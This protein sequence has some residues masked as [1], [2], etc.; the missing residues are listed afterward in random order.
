MNDTFKTK[1]EGS[2]KDKPWLASYPEGVPAEIPPSAYNSLRDLMEKN[3]AAYAGRKVFTSMGKSITYAELEQETRKVAAWLQAHGFRKGDR[4]AV[5]MPNILQNPIAVYGILRAGMIVVNINPLYTAR[6]L[7]YQLKDSGAKV[8]FVLE[9]FAHTAQQAIIGTDIQNV[10]VASIGDVFGAKGILINFVLRRVKK[11][12]PK[13][14]ISCAIRYTD[15]MKEANRLK[16][17]H[18]DIAPED[19]AFLQYTG[20]TTG[21]SKGAVLTHNNLL[22]NKAQ[23]SLWLDSALAGKQRPES[24]TFLCALPLCHIF[25]LTVNSLMGVALGANNVLIA[26][27]R[28]IPALIKEMRHH[29][30][31]VFPG[32]NTL[33]NALLNNDDFKTLDFSELLLVLG[34]GMAVQRPVAERW[35]SVTG[36]PISE[37]YGLSET[38]PVATVNRLD[39]NDFTGTIGLPIPSTE[40]DIR[41]ENDNSLPF[42]EV[43]EICIRGP[44][45][46][47]G[48]WQRPDETAKVMA[49]DGYFRSGDMG[50]MDERGYTKIVDRKK[51]M[52][53]VSGFNV[54]PNEIE[55]VVAS[56]PGVLECAVVGIPDERSGE[57]VKLFVVKKD[58]NLTAEE[59]KAFCAENMTNY[60]RPRQIEFRTELPKTN[61]GKILRREL[62]S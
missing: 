58:P 34:G 19:V 30:F 27:P 35:M 10:V 57:A 3:C 59:L 60:K 9:N 2:A 15:M 40:V 17:V 36:R 49:A 51:D 12:V 4:I 23:I 61:V 7:T 5:M 62:R 31:H 39:V 22:A 1:P 18:T 6:E 28:D 16:M 45:V 50:F 33:F 47:A 44:Q 8:L 29:R 26:N 46:M 20:G 53:L 54:Y 52:I 43:G 42:G 38:S 24:M 48:Y 25:A 21:I 41:D 14:S 55:E 56:H 32:I 11:I 13:W 37:G